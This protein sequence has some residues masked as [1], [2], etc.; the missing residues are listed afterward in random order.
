MPDSI[1]IADPSA[2]DLINVWATV[3]EH[4]HKKLGPQTYATWFNLCVPVSLDKEVFTLACPNN[5]THSWVE[6]NY[7]DELQSSVAAGTTQTTNTVLIV[8]QEACAKTYEENGRQFHDPGAD[9]ANDN[10]TRAG[11]SPDRSRPN[12]PKRLNGALLSNSDFVL[13][14]TYTFEDFV[15]GP[16]NRFAAAL[17]T[18]AA[19]Q[20]GATYNPLF[21]HGSV[22]VGKTHLLQ[23]LCH[24]ILK[25]APESRILYV[26][27]ET[28][29]NHFVS[30]LERGAT[31]TF[32]DRYRHVD[33]LVVDDIHLLANK[34]RTQDE[35][36]HTFN[37]LYNEQKQIVLSSDAPPKEIPTLHARLVSRFGWGIVAEIE[38]PCTETRMAIV[39]RKSR[40]RGKPFPADVNQLIA[41]YII[42][43]VRELEG[44]V[45]RLI[46]YSEMAKR[47]VTTDLAREALG[48]L[49]QTTPGA[50]SV[51]GV[52]KAVTKRYDI[53][54][55]DLQGKRR[56]KS[57]V[58]PRQIAM[59][60][61][62]KL[63]PWSLEEIGAY[64]GGRD[65]STVLHAVDKVMT[66]AR[67][68]EG[69][70]K[71]LT[72]LL[73]DLGGGSLEGHIDKPR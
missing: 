20:P 66:R 56:T 18:G 69:V 16:C 65:H 30:A 13:N 9:P 55:V 4:L 58:W 37:Q 38:A 59:F 29:V 68:E 73:T 60:L 43:N 2:D 3:A 5:F 36:F 50:P 39:S 11:S 64:F 70:R 19:D 45:S 33:V 34:E 71:E 54:L 10:S 41:E 15:I 40:D 23:G 32:R 47:D 53:K 17:A 7:M 61:F 22:G 51:D 25:N 46:A 49:L 35:F 44:A 62:R 27:C 14:P 63:L 24:Q 6:E 8:D 48:D 21:L 1:S 28:F 72:A 12:G 52:V 42:D 67:A 31:D 26:S 57:I